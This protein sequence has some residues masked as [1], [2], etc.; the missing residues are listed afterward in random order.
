MRRRHRAVEFRKF[1]DRVD[2]SAPPAVDAHLIM[3]NY[4]TRKTP[5]IQAWFAKQPPFHVHFD[6]ADAHSRRLGSSSTGATAL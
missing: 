1:L 4:G 2:A 3:N 5:G 6:A